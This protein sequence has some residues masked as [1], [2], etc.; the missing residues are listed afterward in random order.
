MHLESLLDTFII[1]KNRKGKC[2]HNECLITAILDWSQLIQP[3]QENR[4]KDSYSPGVYKVIDS[5]V[6]T[7]L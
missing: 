2:Q 4:W 7:T 3:I 1:V 5:D 6:F